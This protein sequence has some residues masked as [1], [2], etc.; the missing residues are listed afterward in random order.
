MLPDHL[1]HV[2]PEFHVSPEPEQSASIQTDIN[3]FGFSLV[4]MMTKK[5]PHDK[6]L[7]DSVE[8]IKDSQ[9]KELI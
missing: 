3:E 4:E 1:E 9:V 2:F 8:S 6:N 5:A 7:P